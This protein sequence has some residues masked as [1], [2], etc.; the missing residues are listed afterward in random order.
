[1][2]RKLRLLVL[3][4]LLVAVFQSSAFAAQWYTLLVDKGNHP[5]QPVMDEVGRIGGPEHRSTDGVGPKDAGAVRAPQPS[6]CRARRVCREP[7]VAE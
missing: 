5:P 2:T 7:G 1:M 3:V 6:R 4:A